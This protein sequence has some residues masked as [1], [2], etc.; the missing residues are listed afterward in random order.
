MIGDKSSLGAAVAHASASEQIAAA[1]ARL[2]EINKAALLNAA[3]A[4]AAAGW[5]VFPCN[6]TQDAPGTPAAKRRGK[7]P[8]VAGADKDE[9]GN[10]IEKTGG[11]WRATT[12][13]TLIR[14]WWKK[15]P[16]ALIGVPTGAR[17]GLFVV[18]LDPRDG[19]SVEAVRARLE[20]AVGV[21]PYCPISVTQSGGWHL[22]FKNPEGDLPHNS[23]KR[24]AGVD[25]RG[26]GGYVIV[27]PS[28]MSDGK[29]YSWLVP[30]Q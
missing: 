9:H 28:T 17:I 12:D 5:P 23:A 14:A 18:D 26:E 6:P 4:Y 30:P 21:L 15:Y 19:E 22:W 25:W 27:P 29:A 3:L 24:I 13:K 7:K 16:K 11:L 2:E 1:I 8:L 20:E 10:K